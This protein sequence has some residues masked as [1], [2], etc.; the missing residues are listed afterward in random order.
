[1]LDVIIYFLFAKTY[2]IIALLFG[3]KIYFLLTSNYRSRRI[4]K[5]F[6]YNKM[7]LVMT[8]NKKKYRYKKIQNSLSLA[9][10]FCVIIQLVF[11]GTIISVIS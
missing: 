9:I 5:F 2:L 3:I 6:Y 11:F 7:S 1:M 4:S 8:S 10:V